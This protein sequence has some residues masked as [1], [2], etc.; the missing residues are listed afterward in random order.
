MAKSVEMVK[1]AV[2]KKPHDKAVL[3][4]QAVLEKHA[5]DIWVLDVSKLSTV[6]DYFVIGTVGSTRQLKA[7]SDHLDT[8]LAQR[9]ERVWHV[10]GATRADASHHEPQWA[11]LDCG[12]VVVHLLDA[13][14]RSL[15][16]LERLWGDAPRVSVGGA[17][18]STR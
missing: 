9:R 14:A 6:T 16:Q 8:V 10:E 1:I 7:V 4:A 2:P 18:A 13:R 15:Y 17:D 11:L 3:L 5:E 12:D